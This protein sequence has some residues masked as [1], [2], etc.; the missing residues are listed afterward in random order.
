MKSLGRH[1]MDYAGSGVVLTGFLVAALALAAAPEAV[2][3][4][5]G[6]VLPVQTATR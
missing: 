5:A 6:H 1:L 3:T 2:G 4:L